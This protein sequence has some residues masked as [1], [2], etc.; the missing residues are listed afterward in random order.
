LSATTS[1]VT[2]PI[3]GKLADVY[4]RRAVF[5]LGVGLYIVGAVVGATAQ[6]MLQLIVARVVQGLGAG[7]L[8]P[9]AIIVVGDLV[10]ASDRGRWQGLTGAIIG[11]AAVI[12]PT[13]GGWISDHTDWRWVF[14][15][16]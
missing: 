5:I 2:V 1:T 8:V 15:V 12:G 11:G 13:L 14:V 3:Y 4:G 7:A 6:S 10:P 9:L 16:R